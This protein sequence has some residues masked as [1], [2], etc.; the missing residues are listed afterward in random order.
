MQDRTYGHGFGIPRQEVSRLIPRAGASKFRADDPENL[1]AARAAAH[2]AQNGT[3]TSPSRPQDC[4]PVVTASNISQMSVSSGWV[5]EQKQKQGLRRMTFSARS[6]TARTSGR[7]A[8][9]ASASTAGRIRSS[10]SV[11]AC[12]TRRPTSAR[13]S[14]SSVSLSVPTLASSHCAGPI[15]RAEFPEVL[16]AGGDR[17]SG[18]E[19]SAGRWPAASSSS[20]NSG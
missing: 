6:I 9:S 10:A 4:C 17:E 19:L 11:R 16:R 12:P 15:A 7:L 3:S 14:A 8:A 5:L 2:G 1:R 18:T 20:S 13:V